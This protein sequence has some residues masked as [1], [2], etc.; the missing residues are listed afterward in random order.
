MTQKNPDVK[1]LA[2][3]SSDE[4]TP[5]I[6]A[7]ITRLLPQ[8]SSKAA[9][10][11]PDILTKNDCIIFVAYVGDEIVGSLTL[12]HYVTPTAKRARIEDVVV[13]EKYRDAG[14][15]TLLNTAAIESAKKLGAK[16]LDLTSQPTREAANHLYQK[17]GFELRDT[18]TYRKAL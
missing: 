4:I 2:I 12:I 11:T 9:T 16:T 3:E 14:I 8:L 5:E 10:I 13:D 1:I 15:G 18:N 6:T 17:L 7:G